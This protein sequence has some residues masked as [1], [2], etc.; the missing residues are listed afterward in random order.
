MYK[1]FKVVREETKQVVIQ[2]KA[3]GETAQDANSVTQNKSKIKDPSFENRD[4]K[5][6]Q[7]NL[8]GKQ[9]E[10]NRGEGTA[11][12]PSVPRAHRTG[13][14]NEKAEIQKHHPTHKLINGSGSEIKIGSTVTKDSTTH[15]IDGLEPSRFGGAADRV[16][17]HSTSHPELAGSFHPKDIGAKMIKRTVKENFSKYVK[18]KKWR[19]LGTSILKAPASSPKQKDLQAKRKQLEAEMDAKPIKEGRNSEF[20][21]NKELALKKEK[22]KGTNAYHDWVAAKK[23]DKKKPVK[24]DIGMAAGAAGDPGAVQN[25]NSNYAAQKARSTKKKTVKSML[26]RKPVSEKVEREEVFGTKLTKKVSSND[27]RVV[28]SKCNKDDGQRYSCHSSASFMA[29]SNSSKPCGHCGAHF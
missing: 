9:K 6:L 5:K 8:A 15:V 21:A 14:T 7:T 18:N 27:H 12:R 17:T 29:K 23:K 28:C 4:K 26:R 10:P 20:K 16:K 19:R 2:H 11:R 13:L 25:P 3:A 1:S 22:S 24:E